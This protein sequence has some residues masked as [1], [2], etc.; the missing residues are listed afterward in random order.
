VDV[1]EE[2]QK[3]IITC[4]ELT[5][6]SWRSTNSPRTRVESMPPLSL[7]VWPSL[8]FFYQILDNTCWVSCCEGMRWL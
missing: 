3:W 6:K 8:F 7:W 1:T 2:A 4:S 5:S